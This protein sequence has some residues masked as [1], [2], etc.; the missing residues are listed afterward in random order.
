M[1]AA[2]HS[3]RIDM[4]PLVLVLIYLLDAYWWIVIAA[5]IVSWLIA[6]NVI[7]TR[8]HV[9]AM[10]TDVL[11]R[12]TEPAFRPIRN[13]MPNFGG[14]DLSPLIVLLIIF[15]LRAWLADYIYPA[16]P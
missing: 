4:K 13:L 10:I 5:V 7:N 12:L 2:R 3:G 14:L 8:H 1:S 11:W 15:V 6:F 16:V 9:V